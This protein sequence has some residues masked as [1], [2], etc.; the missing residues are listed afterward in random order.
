[1][2]H[3]I[4]NRDSSRAEVNLRGESEKS[5]ADVKTSIFLRASPHSYIKPRTFRKFIRL[6]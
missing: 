6:F 5:G 1:M 3:G 2:V 4:T